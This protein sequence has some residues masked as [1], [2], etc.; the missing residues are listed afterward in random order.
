MNNSDE[1]PEIIVGRMTVIVRAAALM[2]AVMVLTSCGLSAE[3]GHAG[4]EHTASTSHNTADIAF[5]QKM[6]PHHQQAVE[7]SAM[8]P[9]HSTNHGLVVMAKHIQLDQQA[10]IDTLTELLEQWGVPVGRQGHK[11]GDMAVDGMVD[12]ATINQLPSLS[13]EAFD[14]LWIRSMVTH[15]R[16]AV[17]M[18]SEEI[19]AGENPDAVRMA[20]IIVTTQQR[21]IAYLNH[22]LAVAE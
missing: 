17:S 12:Q 18:A 19:A 16:G 10:Q 11:H 13:G 8:V 3:P 2:L 1:R 20:K 4:H 5:A 9:G 15:H 14:A 7:M 21:E 6:I 22:L